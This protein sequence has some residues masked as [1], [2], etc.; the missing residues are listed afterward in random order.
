MILKTREEPIDKERAEVLLRRLPKTHKSY[1]LAK[2]ELWNAE[3]GISGERRFDDYFAM[4]EPDFP[5]IMLNDISLKTALAF[6]L[7]AVMVTPWCLYVFEVKNMSGRLAFKDA[8]LQ[9]IQT[10]E[11][12]SIIGRK[13]PIEQMKQNEWLLDEW[14]LSRNY[15]LPIRSVLVFSYTKQMP[16]NLP[17]SQLA[18]FSHQLPFFIKDI[19]VEKALLSSTEMET[20]ASGLLAS[21]SPF[22]HDP[23]CRNPA[24]PILNMLKGVWC[25]A[26][27]SLGMKRQ[28]GKWNCPSCGAD[29]KDVH[30]RTVRD[31]FLLTGEPI[32]NKFCREILQIDDHRL[33]SR[34]LA[35]MKMNK[36]GSFKDAKYVFE[37]SWEYFV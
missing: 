30:V 3:S 14:L 33:A 7:D 12:G 10:K 22:Q 24:Y 20:L 2:N 21:H 8:P 1:L 9:L 36:T 19:Y 17:K 32:T 4:R 6:Q 29:S 13:S 37:A 31:W 18:I 27:N 25:E 5:Y 23:I 35:G 16:E 34:L 26:C 28:F 15:H 11:D